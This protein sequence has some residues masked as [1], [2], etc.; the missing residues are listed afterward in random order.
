MTYEKL[1]LDVN[2]IEI[3]QKE[4]LKAFTPSMLLDPALLPF[5]VALVGI[6]LAVVIALRMKK[7]KRRW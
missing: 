6:P 2:A 5:V 7:R 1:G 3:L 4:G